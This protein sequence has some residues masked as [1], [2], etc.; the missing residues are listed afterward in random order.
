MQEMFASFNAWKEKFKEKILDMGGKLRS[1]GKILTSE[2][3]T[4]G[5]FVEGKGDRRRL[6]DRRRRELRTGARGRAGKSG[7][8]AGIEHRGPGAGGPLTAPRLVE[9]FFRHEYGRMV[10]LLA[11]KVGVGHIEKV[12]DAVQAALMAALTA[13]TDKGVPHD[14][15]AW[16]YR[17]ACNA[18]IGDLRREG[19]RHRILE[20]AAADLAGEAEIAPQHRLSRV[21]W[22]TTCC[23]CSSSAATTPS[24]GNP[25]WFWP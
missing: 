11:R 22:T 24:H 15:S 5:P 13:W 18:L 10:A 9:H 6:H 19:D 17:M 3:V 21:R 7:A 2:G 20:R 8:Q 14:P 1:G 25:G 12:E 4:D 23:G 16:L